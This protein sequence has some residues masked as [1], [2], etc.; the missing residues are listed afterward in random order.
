MKY[1]FTLF[2][3]FA[4]LINVEAQDSGIQFAHTDWETTLKMAK[5]ENKLI[6]VDC[7][8]DLRT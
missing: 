4:I 8:T 1:L 6:F 3:A 5:E 7:Y 2:F